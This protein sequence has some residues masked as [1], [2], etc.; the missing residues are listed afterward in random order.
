MLPSV[1]P[2][3][4][5]ECGLLS[6]PLGSLNVAAQYLPEITQG[7]GVRPNDKEV[8]L[9]V[10]HEI[11]QRVALDFQFTRHWFGNF[12]ASQNIT[13]PPSAYDTYCVTAPKLKLPSRSLA[14]SSPAPAAHCVAPSGP[15][16]G[17]IALRS[18][19]FWPPAAGA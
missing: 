5:D 2:A 6:A 19:G 4:N 3:L 16:A 14:S 8:A 12:V 11:V 1:N 7:F 17:L 10:Q 13:Q 18:C 15:A 9:G